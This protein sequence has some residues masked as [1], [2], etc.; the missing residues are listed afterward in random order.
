MTPAQV[1]IPLMVPAEHQTQEVPAAAAAETPIQ[2]DR[3]ATIRSQMQTTIHS[4]GYSAVLAAV[5]AA[6]SRLPVVVCRALKVPVLQQLAVAAL[7]TFL[8]AE[9]ILVA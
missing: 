8:V 7:V 5:K 4:P 2:A 3:V 6:V 1:P 9:E